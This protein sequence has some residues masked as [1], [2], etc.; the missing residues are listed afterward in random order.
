MLSLM[1]A[2]SVALVLAMVLTPLLMSFLRRRQM[3]QRIHADVT[4]HAAKEGTPTMGGVAFIFAAVVGYAM[5]HVGT[6]VHF[7]RAGITVLTV[8][9]LAAILG[10]IDDFVSIR[11]A[12]NRGLNKRAK[13]LGQV[14]LAMIFAIVSVQWV[15]TA[16]TL[17]FTRSD[18]PGWQLG[19]VGWSLFAI[20]ALVATSNAVNFTD[21]LDGLVAG[22]A[23]MAFGVLA[24]IGYWQFRHSFIQDLYHLPAALD[25]G[26]VAVSLVGG[27]LGFLWFNAAPARI[28][29]GDTGS[30]ALGFALAGLCLLLNLDALLAILGGIYVLEGVSVVLQIFSFRVFGRRIFKMAPIHHHFELKGWP[31]TTVITR[32]WILAALLAALTLGCFYGDFFHLAKGL[33]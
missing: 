13:F 1:E 3:G 24:I 9:V 23:T 16:T 2:G 5:G 33:Q 21:G 12:R 32:F 28:I 22:S 30:L 19:S 10:F 18:F 17:S 29:M 20:F 8:T 31:E 6:S 15:H 4:Q 27:C 7:T 26:L 11:T 14:I 25:L